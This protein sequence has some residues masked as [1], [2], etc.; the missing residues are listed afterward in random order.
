MTTVTHDQKANTLVVH[1]TNG[2]VEITNW[3]PVWLDSYC[4]FIQPI[5]SLDDWPKTIDCPDDYSNN[6][7][8]FYLLLNCLFDRGKGKYICVRLTAD[9]DK[10]A[11]EDKICLA[12]CPFG[13]EGCIWTDVTYVYL[14]EGPVTNQFVLD[15][16]QL[17][18]DNMIFIKKQGIDSS[19]IISAGKLLNCMQAYKNLSAIFKYAEE[20]QLKVLSNLFQLF[21]KTK[22]SENQ[23]PS[24]E[25][26]PVPNSED[27]Q[28]PTQE[29]I[30]QSVRSSTPES[31]ES[32]Y[33]I[34]DAQ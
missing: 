21:R 34:I 27:N 30:N 11:I 19:N 5:E 13:D 25:P 2:I 14:V 22:I 26:I 16:N 20:Q 3:D 12:L 28:E 7:I 1:V 18:K 29:E 31:T 33:I 23:A 4:K 10:D 6:F 32:D 8:G 9:M 24:Q 17:T 15:I